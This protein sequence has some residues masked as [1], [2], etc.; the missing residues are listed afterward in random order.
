[1]FLATVAI[2]RSC[3]STELISISSTGSSFVEK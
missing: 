1:M 2:V 3:S